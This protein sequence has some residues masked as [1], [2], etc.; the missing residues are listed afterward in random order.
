MLR[1]SIYLQT[2]GVIWFH[3]VHCLLLCLFNN[4]SLYRYLHGNINMIWYEYSCV[5]YIFSILIC[6]SGSQAAAEVM[7]SMCVYMLGGKS[8][9]GGGGIPIAGVMNVLLKVTV[10]CLCAVLSDKYMKDFKE[11][12]CFVP[13][14][15]TCGRKMMGEMRCCWGAYIQFMSISCYSNM[16]FVQQPGKASF[17]RDICRM[18]PFTCSWFSSNVLGVLPFSCAPL[19]RLS[20]KS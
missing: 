4:I 20:Q 9:S 12:C 8:D 1:R 14:E 19:Q 7:F 17:P 15:W 6:H 11:I 5:L 3:D 13:V 2:Q 10:S 16:E 18:S